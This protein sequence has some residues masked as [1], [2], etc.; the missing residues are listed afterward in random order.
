MKKYINLSSVLVA[1]CVFLFTQC[2]K[3]EI[4]LVGSASKANFS[5][6]QSVGSFTLPYPYKVTF[7]DSSSEAFLYQWNFGDNSAFSAEKNPVHYY[8]AGG[9]YYVTLTTV[10]TYG[11][12]STT[13]VISVTDA[14]QYDIFNKLTG[15]S[16]AEWTWSDDDDAIKFIAG[17]GTTVLSSNSAAECQMD[18]VYK[19]SSNGTFSYESNGQ[20]LIQ[21]SGTCSNPLPNTS[22]FNV[23]VMPG[24]APKI[25]L[26][27]L[28]SGLNGNPFL[29]TTDQVDGNSYEV[30]SFSANTLT[31]RGALTNQPG[32]YIE[33][34]LKKVEPLT[35]DGI[36]NILTGGSSRSWVL[37]P[38]GGANSIVVGTEGNPSEY[39]G[40]GPLEPNCQVDDV[41]TFSISNSL[42][43]N[44]GGSTFNGGN[45][46]PNYN[47]GDDRSFTTSY[48]Y[49]AVV[50][51]VEGLAQIKL[52]NIPPANFIGTTDVPTENLYRI[53]EITP[54]RM[55]LRA[56]TGAGVVFQFKF[57]RQ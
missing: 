19:F 31:I 23:S 22:E 44:S 18:D 9:T 13:K 49:G 10:G 27:S 36:K 20:T 51:G 2:K 21:S 28:A 56:G 6:A 42:N 52:P 14:C 5:Y 35:L 26:G 33:V 24:I 25:N 53:I 8:K 29:G 7:T 45:I 43:Y 12:N 3:T 16:T 11:N 34:K 17:D 4:E 38:A 46:S 40:G 41:Y 48:E 55:V 54:T 37:D 57:V 30:R 39:Y 1:S 50:G 15:C 32:N 47:C